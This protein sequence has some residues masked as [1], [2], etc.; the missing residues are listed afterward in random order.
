[1][2]LYKYNCASIS[3][4]FQNILNIVA[5]YFY[6]T[7]NNM[8]FLRGLNNRHMVVANPLTPIFSPRAVTVWALAKI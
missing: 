4:V 3:H 7:E 8:N 5:Q 1:M 2:T 6:A